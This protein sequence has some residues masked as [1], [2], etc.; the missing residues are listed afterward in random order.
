[1]G[2]SCDTVVKF[3]PNGS[4]VVTNLVDLKKDLQSMDLNDL[5]S[6]EGISEYKLSEFVDKTLDEINYA[7]HVL[8]KKATYFD[9]LTDNLN[10][11]EKIEYLKS[12]DVLA[13]LCKFKSKTLYE[14]QGVTFEVYNE[15]NKGLEKKL[16]GIHERLNYK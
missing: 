10:P 8:F 6:V 15:I 4:Y 3:H 5:E 11:V 12:L 9:K 7:K 1:M 13:D 14:S 2:K 16:L